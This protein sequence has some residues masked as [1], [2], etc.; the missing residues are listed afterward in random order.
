MILIEKA[1]RGHLKDFL[2]LQKEF[3]KIYKDLSNYKIRY[4]KKQTY[5]EFK[6]RFGKDKFFYFVKYD[7]SII[8]YTYGHIE[9]NSYGDFA[10]IDDIFISKDYQGKGISTL[11]KNKILSNFKKNKINYCRIDVNLNNSRA[12]NVYK[13]WGFKIDKFRMNLKI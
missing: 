10:Y 2:R 13:H 7:K 11:L 1:K 8:G 5:N 3:F 6:S 9:R 12:I 4:S